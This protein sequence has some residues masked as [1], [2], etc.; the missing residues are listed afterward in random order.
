MGAP[1]G[2]VIRLIS[3]ALVM[4]L[5]LRSHGPCECTEELEGMA[6]HGSGMAR[7]PKPRLVGMMN[8]MLLPAL[9]ACLHPRRI[10]PR[11]E[12]RCD[13]VIERRSELPGTGYAKP[14]LGLE[15]K[16]ARTM[17]VRA[18]SRW[19]FLRRE[20]RR[21]AMRRR[22]RWWSKSRAIEAAV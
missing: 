20:A 6:M 12:S 9:L 16:S 22:Y 1:G 2:V 13:S 15:R 5:G 10:L 17:R 18:I 14:L 4:S 11:A 21:L 8:D 7:I 3:H 19:Q